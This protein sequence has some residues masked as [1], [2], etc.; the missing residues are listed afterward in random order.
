MKLIRKLPPKYINGKCVSY[1]IFWC[2]GCKQEVERTLSSGKVAK[3]CGCQQHS[4]EVNQKIAKANKG[5]KNPM[6]GKKQTKDVKQKIKEI[7]IKNGKFK[8]INNPMYGKRGV[9]A[10]NWQD[11]RSF[12][13]YPQEFKQIREFI[14]ERDNYTCQCPDC[15]HKTNLL[16]AHHI[17]YDKKNNNPKNLTTLCRSCHAKTFG[18]NNKQYWTEFY[19]NIMMNRVINCLV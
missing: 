8:G 9:E 7:H 1:G 15:E 4:K 17:D 6:Y 13:I 11:G 16:D 14:Y 19:Q 10:G 18:K 3:S 12:E 5:E 2:E